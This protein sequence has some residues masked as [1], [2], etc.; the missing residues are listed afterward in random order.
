MTDSVQPTIVVTATGDGGVWSG[1]PIEKA[2]MYYE[3]IYA[4]GTL[5]PI[6][7]GVELRPFDETGLLA[8]TLI[9][10]YDS[11]S[12]KPQTAAHTNI[13]GWSDLK[14]WKDNIRQFPEIIDTPIPLFDKQ[15]NLPWL[16]TSLDLSILDAQ[17]DSANIG[18]YQMNFINGNSSGDVQ[19]PFIETRNGAILNSAQAIKSIMFNKDGTQAAPKDYLM[20]MTLFIYDKNNRSTR[21]FEVNHLVALQTTSVPMD[22]SNTNGVATVQLG[23]LKMF[24]MLA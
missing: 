17:N 24:P 21:V 9:S 12:L 1:M 22:A 4:M 23:F 5:S 18:H 2:L 14:R 16:A 8:T 6:H 3:E 11:G 7:Y 13:Q 15:Y 20:V 10:M 19:I